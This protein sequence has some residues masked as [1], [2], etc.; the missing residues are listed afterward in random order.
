MKLL[1]GLYRSV[2]AHARLGFVVILL[3]VGAATS[4]HSQ[5]QQGPE[6]VPTAPSPPQ[7]QSSYPQTEAGFSEQIAA[8]LQSYQQGDRRAE[9][10][11]VEQL[12]LPNAAEWFADQ[13][14]LEQKEA[15]AERYD[16]LFG[17]FSVSMRAAMESVVDYKGSLATHCEAAP[18]K[19]PSAEPHQELSRIVPAKK[20]VIIDCQFAMTLNGATAASWMENFA[21]VEEAFR[22]T[23]YGEWPFWVW[24][25][26]SEGAPPATGQD[27][28]RAV[29][30]ANPSPYYPVEARAQGREGIVVLS[31]VIDA[32]GHVQ[33]ISVI[34]G[35]PVFVKAAIEAFKKWRYKPATFWGQPIPS[36]TTVTI[37]FQLNR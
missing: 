37:R 26:G 22:F 31:G 23:G 11:F 32:T 13:I 16:R 29:L 27:I 30:I 2:K 19:R 10:Q 24:N 5:N 21:Y 35:D 9:H 34:N 7:T 17:G 1:I 20:P 6:E 3:C 12:Y 8:M 4:G 36:N 28:Q 14:G 18:R 15:L 25:E 33:N